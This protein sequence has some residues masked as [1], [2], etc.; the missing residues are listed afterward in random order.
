MRALGFEVKKAEVQ[1]YLKE[2]SREDENLI[3]ERDFTEIG[4][5]CAPLQQHLC[6]Y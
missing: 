5:Y 3:N 6:I 1:R 4:A 2:Y